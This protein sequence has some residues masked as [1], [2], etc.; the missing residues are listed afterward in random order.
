MTIIYSKK[1]A[2]KGI[3]ETVA[4]FLKLRQGL[5]FSLRLNMKNN[6]YIFNIKLEK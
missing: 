2:E 1:N 6:T 3:I 4:I 5:E